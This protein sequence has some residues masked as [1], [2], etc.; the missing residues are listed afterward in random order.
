MKGEEK[1]IEERSLTS[2]LVKACLSIFIATTIFSVQRGEDLKN[3]K[4]TKIFN[5]FF[6]YS[7]HYFLYLHS[8]L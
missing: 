8:L 2:N 5:E 3:I 6:Y 7:H 4:F 1:E